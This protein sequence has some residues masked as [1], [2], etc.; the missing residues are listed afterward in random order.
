MRTVPGS[1]NSADCRS[2]NKTTA[3]APLPT[4]Y[5][6]PP[7]FSQE[8]ATGTPGERPR[9]RLRFRRQFLNRFQRNRPDSGKERKPFPLFARKCLMFCGYIV[10]TEKSY[11]LPNLG[12]SRARCSPHQV[13]DRREA[14]SPRLAAG[15]PR[16]PGVSPVRGAAKDREGRGAGQGPGQAAAPIAAPGAGRGGGGTAAP[17]SE[18]C[19]GRAL[20]SPAASGPGAAGAAPP[21]PPLAPPRVACRPPRSPREVRTARTRES[22]DPHAPRSPRSRRTTRLPPAP[23]HAA[24][25]LGSPA[26]GRWAPRPSVRGRLA[27]GAPARPAGPK[28]ARNR[29]EGFHAKVPFLCLGWSHQ[30]VFLFYALQV[31]QILCVEFVLIL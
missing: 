3:T 19:A 15:R 14:P 11:K 1:L 6:Y 7:L 8:T 4:K 25:A 17:A 10:S 9:A 12:S 5:Q 13:S 16:S 27:L 24:A 20:P 31:F 29:L 18:V 28:L 26:S 21:A 22:A 2:L 23:Q 30:A